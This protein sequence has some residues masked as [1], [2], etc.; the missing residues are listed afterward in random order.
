MAKHD[1]MPRHDDPTELEPRPRPS[2]PPEPARAAPLPVQP[3]VP[4][5][6]QGDDP[7][8]VLVR[9]LEGRQVDQRPHP[10]PRDGLGPGELAPS[11]RAATGRTGLR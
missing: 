6:D 9:P 5:R 4:Q 2:P 7:P 10:L 8:H 11:V 1:D 3:S